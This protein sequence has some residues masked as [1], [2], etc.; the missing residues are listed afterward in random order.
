[1]FQT[2]VV[3]VRSPQES[4]KAIPAVAELAERVGAEVRVVHVLE[5]AAVPAPFGMGGEG[6][7]IEEDRAAAQQLLD[8]AVARFAASGVRASAKLVSS[9]LPVARAILE[10]AA[11]ARADLLVV[12]SRGLSDLGGLLLGSVA[13]KVIHLA[14]CSV[15]VLR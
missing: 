4:L 10:V 8:D 2:I 15:L 1:M 12:G 14:K 6:G 9:P 5:T 3:A 13:L 11:E 7:F